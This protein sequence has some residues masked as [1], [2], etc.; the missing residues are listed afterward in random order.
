MVRYEDIM[1][2]GVGD[3]QG[4]LACGSAWDCKKKDTTE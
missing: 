4:S 3:G 2:L 1:S